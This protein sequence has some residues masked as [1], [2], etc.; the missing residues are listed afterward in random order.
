MSK[1]IE[2]VGL[3]KVYGMKRAVDTVSLNI[4]KGEIYGLIG[5]NGAGK[6]TLMKLVLGL[7]FANSGSVRLFESDELSS[8]RRRIGSLIESPAIYPEESAYGNLRRFG[9]LTG[10][11]DEEIRRIIDLVGLADAGKKLAGAYSLGM[12]QRLGIAIA[13]LGSPDLLILDEPVNGLDPAGIKDVRDLLLELNSK[14]VTIFI[15]SHLLDELGRIATKFGIMRD[16]KLVMEIKREELEAMAH[17][18]IVITVSDAER[19]SEI[20]KATYPE[21]DISVKDHTVEVRSAQL[22]PSAVNSALVMGGVTV[23]ELKYRSVGIED[24]FIERMGV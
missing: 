18:S 4:E 24:F 12:K 23:N 6:T 2:T 15:S 19:S 16:G 8:A 9:M 20:I 13:L 14:G 3:T 5:K 17:D 22:E 7:A 10:S 11:G 21:A 1:V